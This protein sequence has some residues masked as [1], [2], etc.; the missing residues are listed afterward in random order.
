MNV[1][2]SIRG[3]VQKQEAKNV[4]RHE[5]NIASEYTKMVSAAR[6]GKMGVV[7]ADKFDREVTRSFEIVRGV[8]MYPGA[9]AGFALDHGEAARRIAADIR[10]GKLNFDTVETKSASS[11]SV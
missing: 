9:T 1:F 4:A 8:T 11:K 3:F 7:T 6:A 5:K 10:S 2:Q